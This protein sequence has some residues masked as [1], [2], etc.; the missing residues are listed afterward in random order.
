MKISR[1]L[2]SL[3][4]LIRHFGLQWV[5]FRIGYFIRM[6]SGLIRWQIPAYEW[7]DRPL[8]FWLKNN[9]PSD[10]EGY[11]LWRKENQSHFL[12]DQV[13]SIPQSV[14]WDQFQVV[15]E[16]DHYLAGITRFFSKTDYQTGFPPDWHL[17]P[18]KNTRIIPDKH[19]SQ[20]S[21]NGT[22]D[23]KFVWEAS[24][25]SQIY[26]LVRAYARTKDDNY[27][28]AFWRILEDWMT[29][30]PPGMGPNWMDG[31][32][33]ALRLMAICFG[34]SAFRNHPLTS[35]EKVEQLT[36]LVA[37]LA[38]RIYKNIDYA[39]FTRSNHTISEGL[40]IWLV[41]T[42]FPE[43]KHAEKYQK[44]GKSILEKEACRQIYPD[45][46]YCM[47]SLNY[48]RFVLH[49]FMFALRIG[50]L[51]ESKLSICVY[52]A[53]ER[54]TEYLYQLIDPA[55]GLMPQYGSND[56]A[57]VMLL[58]SCDFTD[59][60][61]VIQL[62]HYMIKKKLV[63]PPGP[64][65]EDLFWFYGDEAL[66]SLIETKNQIPDSIFLDSGISKISGD[67]TRAFIRCGT[68]KDRPSHADQNHLDLWW[69]GKNIAVDAGTYLYSGDQHWRNG[70][71]N[72]IVHNTVTV[73]QQDQ[74][75]RFS[76]FIWVNWSNGNVIDLKEENGFKYWQGQ[77]DG[78]TRLKDPVL[79]KRTVALLENQA[80]LVVDHVAGLKD[81][82]Y[83]LNWLL[84]HDFSIVKG[85]ENTLQ[86][87]D[88]SK[89][90][91]AKFGI[92]GTQIPF[93]SVSADPN[94]PRGWLSRYYGYKQPALSVQL[95]TNSQQ[96][97][98]WSFFGPDNFSINA[99]QDN[100]MIQ[101][102]EW[103]AVLDNISLMITQPSKDWGVS[104]NPLIKD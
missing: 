81:H 71:A 34:F 87:K 26:T 56:G 37:S 98:F 89:T 19:W 86:M 30:N 84:D 33:A 63:F 6:R 54:S 48:H 10:P 21:D 40:G 4:S 75:H 42:L 2:L 36:I 8:S 28:E 83:N 9:V 80:W 38:D 46:S 90:L 50:E 44:R 66:N 72:T 69:Q 104:I 15:K 16:A 76:R 78:Y 7:D 5:F 18:L 27:C 57:L 55:T 59:Y 13:N 41:G 47:H 101:T 85:E 12:F 93:N 62:G 97:L 68:I 51:N 53:I 58:N 92:L 77:H 94:S 64:W 99:A 43:L 11:H 31:Q 29:H 95:I 70:L 20:I 103:Q 61:P 91:V 67:S 45:G 96:A 60:R 24:R 65:D 100:L 22:Y 73:D 49:I 3:P 102:K 23:I 14:S 25:L 52:Q 1:S 82:E 17:D 74:M 32:E 35:N 88:Q 79:H 39:I